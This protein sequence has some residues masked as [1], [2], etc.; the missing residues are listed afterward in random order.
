MTRY[1]KIIYYIG[2]CYIILWTTALIVWPFLPFEFSNTRYKVSC[3]TVSAL[4]FAVAIVFTLVKQ[5]GNAKP[6]IN[7]TIIVKV[8]LALI[9]SLVALLA[10]VLADFSED[11]ADWV[12]FKNKHNPAKNVVLRYIDSDMSGNTRYN[13][14]YVYRLNGWFNYAL[15][16]DTVSIDRQ[17]WIKVDSK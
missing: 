15:D 4:V 16:I 1:G 12:V 13:T 10:Y 14:K 2:L 9:V 11:R 17:E 8:G 3:F 5:Y 7:L 6:G